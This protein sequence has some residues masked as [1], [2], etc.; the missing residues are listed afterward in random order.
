[1]N[2]YLVGFLIFA[3]EAVLIVF[4]CLAFHF[5]GYKLGYQRGRQDAEKWWTEAGK[6]VEAERQKIWREEG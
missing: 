6:E 5:R 2:P 4:S 3:G 1:M